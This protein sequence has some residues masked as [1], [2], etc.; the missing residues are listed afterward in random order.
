MLLLTACGPS[1]TSG[2]ELLLQLLSGRWWWR[3]F[4]PPSYTHGCCFFTTPRLKISCKM[5]AFLFSPLLHCSTCC[6]NVSFSLCVLS[7]SSFSSSTSL[8]WSIGRRCFDWSWVCPPWWRCFLS[9]TCIFFLRTP[10]Q[11]DLA[12]LMVFL[13][14][15]RIFFVHPKI[16]P[17]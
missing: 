1:G 15:T 10:A 4:I 6:L 13:R 17:L 16:K 11:P 3:C 12:I 7:H 9:G 5:S 2:F 14:L 8:C